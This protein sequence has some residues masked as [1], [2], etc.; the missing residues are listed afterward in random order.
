ML[1]KKLWLEAVV[2]IDDKTA[3]A[4]C[5]DFNALFKIDLLSG[6]CTYI[7]TFSQEKLGGKRLYA[8]G[9]LNKN[10]IYFIPTRASAISVYDLETNLIEY[11]AIKE[12]FENRE[13]NTN[14]KFSE[15]FVYGDYIYILPW[16]YPAVVRLNCLDNTLA[17]MTENLPTNNYVFRLGSAQV[18]N[19]IYMPNTT[20]NLVLEID[21]ENETITQHH[22]GNQNNGSWS[23]VLDGD[24]LWLIPKMQ[25][26]FVKWDY[27]NDIVYEYNKYPKEYKESDFCFTKGYKIG[28][29]ICVLPAKAN[30][31]L[32]LNTQGEI[33]EDNRFLLKPNDTVWYMFDIAGYTYL[34]ITNGDEG[35][36]EFYRLKIDE[37]LMQKWEFRFAYGKERYIKE[38]MTR[39]FNQKANIKENEVCSGIKSFL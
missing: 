11:I 12:E 34:F 16:T 30:L 4:S 28:E 35:E 10:K 1:D 38:Y 33:I 14:C 18:G 21:L 15:A 13:Y 19:K 22:I 37:G 8:N 3:Y 26:A 25:G 23:V 17:Y 36:R 7:D 6:D 29:Y 39:I 24:C 27:V 20:D 32:K 2:E 31:F 9:V 5:S